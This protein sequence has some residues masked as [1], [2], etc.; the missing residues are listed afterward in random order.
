MGEEYAAFH[1]LAHDTPEHTRVVHVE[2]RKPLTFH[3][4]YSPRGEG[5]P[6]LIGIREKSFWRTRDTIKFYFYECRAHK[7]MIITCKDIASKDG[8][9]FKTILINLEILYKILDMKKRGLI[10][11][12]DDDEVDDSKDISN[13]L[14]FKS[15]K[16][17]QDDDSLHKTAIDY[18]EKRLN[19]SADPVDWPGFDEEIWK[20]ELVA[21]TATE[22]DLAAQTTD[23]ILDDDNDLNDTATSNGNNQPQPN[24]PQRTGRA[25]LIAPELSA[26]VSRQL[27]P[28]GNERMVVFTLLHDDKETIELPVELLITFKVDL[29][30]I[31][32]TQ[33]KLQ[34]A[35]NISA[36][37][38]GG[39]STNTPVL[40]RAESKEE[41]AALLALAAVDLDEEEQVPAGLSQSK[42]K[43]IGK[44][45]S[46]TPTDRGSRKVTPSKA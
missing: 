46:K 10:G 32:E 11:D 44:S 1:Y 20:A 7:F 33:L 23:D 43:P 30:G 2:A 28:I 4:L 36:N 27:K 21:Q 16:V 14:K 45:P 18:L 13:G 15:Q 25:A 37:G 12:E 29:S 5:A 41:A 40:S 19:I 39:S 9:A 8:T 38:K 24:S 31:E 17:F 22:A 35:I 34:P 26:D 3:E 42:Q 6:I